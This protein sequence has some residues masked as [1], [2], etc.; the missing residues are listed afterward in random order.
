MVAPLSI[1]S[2]CDPIYSLV[3][4]L[5]LLSYQKHINTNIRTG[6]YNFWPSLSPRFR[7]EMNAEETLSYQDGFLVGFPAEA[8]PCPCFNIIYCHGYHLY[9][10]V[11]ERV[12]SKNKR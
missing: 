12:T 6:I 4:L 1:V 7:F 9:S 8:N 11:S 5:D 2:L 3:G 10:S